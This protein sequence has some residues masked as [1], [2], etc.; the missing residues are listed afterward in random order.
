M[1]YW[2]LFSLIVLIAPFLIGDADAATWYNSSWLKARQITIDQTD[3]DTADLTNYPLYVNMTSV[4]IGTDAQAD[5]DDFVFTDSTNVTKLDHEIETC[6][7]ADNWAEFWVEVPTVDFDADTVIY[8]YYDNAAASD[9]Q[10]TQETW[11]SNYMAVLHLN[12][13]F[14]DS[15]TSPI[16]CTNSGST[17]NTTDYIGNSR[18]FDGVDDVI[19]CNSASKLDAIFN[20]GGTVS[21]W[22]NPYT[23]GEGGVGRIAN[24][25]A[26]GV[27]GWQFRVFTPLT[28]GYMSLQLIQEGSGADGNW[29]A[30][31]FTR[32]GTFS[33]VVVTYNDD[34]DSNDPIFYVNGTARTLTDG[35]VVGARIDTTQNL[36][37]GNAA[38]GAAC[39]TTTTFE[40]TIDDVR[41]YDIIQTPEWIKADWECQRGVLDGNSCITVGSQG[42]EPAAGGTVT[43][44]D[45]FA[46]EDLVTQLNYYGT[47]S[48]DFALEDTVTGNGS[49]SATV[50]LADDFAIEDV[51]GTNTVTVTDDFAIE[52]SQ[53][54]TSVPAA[55]IRNAIVIYLN[56]PT[57]TRLGG[58]F[59]GLCDFAN[60]YTMIGIQANGTI[61]CSKLP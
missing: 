13:T 21:A 59:A 5:C 47:V 23:T 58:V 24:K 36:C 40:G 34:D 31:G 15:T 41:L 14:I 29:Q 39:V 57:T 8:M 12:N 51:A 52:D 25:F 32:Q 11:N 7:D 20:G 55:S 43:V 2:A 42:T 3:I 54:A 27:A 30:V 26:S 1:R 60:N 9:Q 56:S 44:A 61:A 16:T 18:N 33:H 46:L 37:I 45:D 53:P 4:N 19:D 48:D 35:N 6:S 17:A 22:I 50:T 10:N 38:T 49:S 28:S